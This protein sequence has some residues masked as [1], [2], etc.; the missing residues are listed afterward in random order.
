MK[1]KTVKRKRLGDVLIQQGSLSEV[2][3]NFAISLQQ[4]RVTRLG[5]LLLKEGLVSKADIGRALEHVQ[6]IPYVQCPPQ[7][8]EPEV[9]AKLPH[10]IAERCCA[11]PLSIDGRELVVALAEPQN[12]RIID[13][14]QFSSGMVISPR[15][16]FRED[17]QDAIARFYEGK[18]GS[19][20]PM[21][22]DDRHVT[23][24]AD[25]SQNVEFIV[26][27]LGE[28][29]R[30]AQQEKQAGVKL[31]TP[32]VRF[33]SSIL[34]QSAEKSASDIHIEPR[35][36][37]VL[38]RVRID[39]VLRDLTSIPAEHRASVISRIKILANM[40]IAERRVPQDGRFLMRYRGQRLDLRI[41]TLPTHFGEKVVIRLLDPRS[42]LLAFD[43]LGFSEPHAQEFMRILRLPQ[44]MVL[45]TGPTGS[46]KST[47]LYSALNL[48]RAP[49]RNIITVED[50]VEYIMDGINQVQVHPK[51]GLTFSSVLPSLLR[52]DPDAIMVGEIRDVSTA[53]IA[54][55]ASQTGQM[56]F[57][58]L[59]T[60]DS[61][62]AIARLLNLGVPSYLIASSITAVLA[63]RLVRRLCSCRVEAPLSGTHERILAAFGVPASEF[64][65]QYEP[66]G[67]SACDHTGYK[68]RVGIYEMLSMDGPIR[69]AV[70]AGGRANEIGD[71]AR[72]SGF[73]T[74]QQD[75]IDKVRQGTTTLEE[76]R[77]E[78]PVGE[79]EA[80]RT[81]RCL[82]CEREI[83]T[84]SLYCSHCGTMQDDGATPFGD[85]LTTRR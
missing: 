2:D 18:I 56:V 15:F 8:V 33:V 67:C 85:Q 21:P 28:E 76:I 75:A 44:G 84:S 41:S 38:V 79:P 22:D 60:N 73:R 77:R 40:D 1:G 70:F 34:A 31:R 53:E 82:S 54:M 52:Q 71:L 13:E 59:H 64:F 3:L 57:S 37:N 43:Q 11:M 29:N 63:Q 6:G 66:V 24:E 4:E 80:A 47:T 48:L 46:G 20:R 68:G 30:A 49:D 32:A 39:G 42:T 9:L 74:M 69:D 23:V 19:S 26:K 72:R 17:V 27:D 36:G 16:S 78:V 25:S 61:I 51:A 35:D 45:V 14:L 7:S 55:K 81:V 58:T 83:A 10:P 62:S 12:L 65:S 5:D 50:P